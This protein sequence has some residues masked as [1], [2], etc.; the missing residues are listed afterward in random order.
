MTSDDVEAEWKFEL[1]Q[2]GSDDGEEVKPFFGRE[3][4]DRE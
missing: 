2:T 1:V 3:S 4:G